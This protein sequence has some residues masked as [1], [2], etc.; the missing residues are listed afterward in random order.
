MG[1]KQAKLASKQTTP[2]LTAQERIELIANIVIEIIDE[3]QGNAISS[4]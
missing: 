1:E 4:G 2:V 3:E